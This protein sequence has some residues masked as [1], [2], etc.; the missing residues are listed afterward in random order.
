M[1]LEVFLKH[2]RVTKVAQKGYEFSHISDLC[3]NEN[4]KNSILKNSKKI[5]AAIA[6]SFPFSLTANA[7]D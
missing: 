5:E 1:L 6:L 3:L 4:Q 7:L 2:C